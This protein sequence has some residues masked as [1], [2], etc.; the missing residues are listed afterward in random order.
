MRPP[1]ILHCYFVLDTSTRLLYVPHVGE[2]KYKI[3]ESE[4]RRRSTRHGLVFAA[5]RD[6]S[7]QTQTKIGEGGSFPAR[8]AGEFGIVC[9]RQRARKGNKKIKVGRLSF[10]KI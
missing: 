8:Q 6:P 5:S 1:A 4:R 9:S 2:R 10:G 3:H 7:I